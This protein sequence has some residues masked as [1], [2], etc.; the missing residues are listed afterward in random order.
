MPEEVEEQRVEKASE[1]AQ[2][3]YRESVS[4]R[5]LFQGATP[6]GSQPWTRD[7]GGDSDSLAEQYIP[8]PS[9]ITFPQKH[10]R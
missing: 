10:D 8:S 1:R 4:E 6:Q 5:C 9:R 2:P 3:G 7:Q